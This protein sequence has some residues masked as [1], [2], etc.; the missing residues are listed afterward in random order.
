MANTF[1]MQID[2][3]GDGKITREEIYEYYKEWFKIDS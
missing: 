2:K 1:I 3:D